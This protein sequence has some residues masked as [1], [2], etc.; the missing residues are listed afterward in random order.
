MLTRRG[1]GPAPGRARAGGR[2]RQPDEEGSARFVVEIADQPIA[3]LPPAVRQVFPADLLG[4]A[5]EIGGKV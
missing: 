2:P 4:M 3:T 5:R 1:I